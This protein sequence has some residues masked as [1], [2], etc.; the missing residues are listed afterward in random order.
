MTPTG[1]V[2]VRAAAIVL[3]CLGTFGL[4]IDAV[5]SW[6]AEATVRILELFGVDGAVP[7]GSG[8]IL[9][10]PP[11]EDAFIGMVT[12]GCSSLGSVLAAGV[13]AT[14]ILVGPPGRRLLA[15][16]CSTALIVAANLIRLAVSVAVGVRVGDDALVLFHNWAAA[17]FAFLYLLAALVLVLHIMLPSPAEAVPMESTT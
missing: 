10:L 15:L 14:L 8:A 6:E 3:L 1:P 2:G 12:R 13:L 7:L 9:I 5:R 16:V 17:L 4:L 11:Q